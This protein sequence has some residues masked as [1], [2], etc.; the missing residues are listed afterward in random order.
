MGI[1]HFSIGVVLQSIVFKKV[2]SDL[3]KNKAELSGAKIALNTLVCS[4][5]RGLPAC[6]PCEV[7]SSSPPWTPDFTWDEA[8]C[9]S[10]FFPLARGPWAKI[11]TTGIF[12]QY[13]YTPCASL[14]CHS[15]KLGSF[16]PG[17]FLCLDPISVVSIYL[18]QGQ[19]HALPWYCDVHRPRAPFLPLAAF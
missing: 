12:S 3:C 15:G 18:G 13:F 9:T 16:W 5:L 14:P 8:R 6:L 10:V 1:Y 11:Q 2:I 4:G 19:T 7:F 17:S